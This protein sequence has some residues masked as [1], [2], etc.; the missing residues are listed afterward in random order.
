MGFLFIGCFCFSFC[1]SYAFPIWSLIFLSFCYVT[2]SVWQPLSGQGQSLRMTS[3]SEASATS[4]PSVTEVTHPSAI[5]SP[6]SQVSGMSL[7]VSAA[8]FLAPESEAFTSSCLLFPC[9]WL[10]V[11]CHLRSPALLCVFSFFS[12]FFSTE[13]ISV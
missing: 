1:P 13:H 12:S 5:V 11:W 8:H 3:L 4:Q 2:S 10:L 9:D 7:V 6:R